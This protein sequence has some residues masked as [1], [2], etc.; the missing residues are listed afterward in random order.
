MRRIIITSLCLVLLALG[1]QRAHGFALL[2]P[3]TV[4][5][6]GDAWETASIGYAL[7][8]D[9]G[10]PKDFNQGYRRNL[11]IMYYGCDPNFATWFGPQGEQSLD[12]AFNI[13]TYTFTN[14]GAENLNGYSTNLVEF[15]FNSQSYNYTAEALGLTDLKS[16]VLYA[17]MEEMGLAEPERYVWG[18]HDRYLPPGGTCPLDEEYFVIQRNFYYTP[19]PL[20]QVLY[21]PYV[22]DTLY[23]YTISEHCT[24][25]NPLAVTVPTQVDPFA[26]GDTAV[27]GLG[28]G[29]GI[30]AITSTNTLGEAIWGAP[31]AGGYYNGLTRDD[32]GGLRWLMGTNNIEREN[33]PPGVFLESTNFNSG[34]PFPLTTSPLGPLLQFA[35]TNPPTAVLAA[36]PGLTIDNVITNYTLATNP[37]VVSYFTNFYG[38]PATPSFVVFTNGYTYGWATN[39]IYTFGNLVVFNYNTNTPALLETI[40]LTVPYGEPPNYFVTNVSYQPIT[41]NEPSGQYYLMPSNSC[42]FDFVI[43]NKLNIF[44]GTYTNETI[45]LATNTTTIATGFVGTQMIVEN[46]TNSLLQYYPCTLV[47]NGPDYYRGI[48]TCQFIRVPD[49]NIDPTLGTLRSPITNTYVMYKWNPTNSQTTKEY[50]YRVL[51]QPDFLFSGTDLTSPSGDIS[52]GYYT[53][54]RNVNF[55][56]GTEF[57]GAAGPGTIFPP[58]T[59]TLNLVGDLFGNG[60]LAEYEVSTN[61]LLSQQTAG[62]LLAWASFDGTTNTPIVYPNG[63][64][65]QDLENELVVTITPS[66]LP[67]GTNNVAYPTI[68]FS[69]TGGQ[70]PYSWSY[71]GNLPEGLSFY[72][73]VLSGTPVNNSPAP[74]QNYGTYDFNIILTDSF[75]RVVSLPYTINIYTNAP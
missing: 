48:G 35:Q 38:Y 56:T 1:W 7:P 12:A 70:P 72:N 58:S 68:N 31:Y 3:L 59:I 53:Y 67:N 73:G 17:M 51:T 45:T 41:L 43:T 75:N 63:T 10:T 37:I 26:N 33:T 66:T 60:S 13:L 8:G 25:P 57:T 69:A 34:Y 5:G 27:A 71:S 15:P 4:T 16:T 23:T 42:G 65:F 18:L 11:P 29:L 62:G 36:F 19:S 64:S 46:L 2:G 22:N 50:F 55:D 30:E 49:E 74:G 39:Y 20:N 14:N 40:Q 44:A 21:S 9:I 54:S 61:T 6:T 52:L 28:Q 47:T 24:G 32:V